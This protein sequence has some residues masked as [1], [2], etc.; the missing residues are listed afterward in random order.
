MRPAQRVIKYLA[1]AFAACLSIAIISGIIQGGYFLLNATGLVGSE[2]K[3]TNAVFD[4]NSTYLSVELGVCDLTIERS[5]EVE[6]IS[7]ETNID[8]VIT[9]QENDSLTIKNEKKQ[10]GKL[11]NQYAKLIVNENI[12]FDKVVIDLGVG[13]VNIKDVD[14]ND[15]SVKTGVGEI[16]IK[17]NI[18]GDSII[19]TGIGEAKIELNNDE[20]EYTFEFNKGIGE[21]TLNGRSVDDGKVGNGFNHIK[22]NAGIGEINIKTR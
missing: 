20:E 16:N 1:I 14:M 19:D 10:F 15:L 8:G 3:I 5:N 21:A 22:V 18:T 9:N 6:G 2:E 4:K 13:E 12:K 11:S 7:F 17:S